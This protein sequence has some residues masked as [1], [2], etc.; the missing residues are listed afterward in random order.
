MSKTRAPSRSQADVHQLSDPLYHDPVRDSLDNDC[1]TCCENFKLPRRPPVG[2]YLFD[3]GKL[4]VRDLMAHTIWTDGDDLSWLEPL[5]D[6]RGMSDEDLL[7]LSI[8]EEF[9]YC[10]LA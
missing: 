6:V 9:R 5:D 8:S 4:F 2:A 7:V 1:P 10:P 3:R